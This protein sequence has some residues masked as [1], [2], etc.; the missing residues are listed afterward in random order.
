MTPAA[1]GQKTSTDQVTGRTMIQLRIIRMLQ[2]MTTWI[3]DLIQTMLLGSDMQ[4]W[5]KDHNGQTPDANTN[6]S[7]DAIYDAANDQGAL[8]QIQLLTQLHSKM[9]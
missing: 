2:R 6:Y 1:G 3:K 5:M 4:Q 8:V 9:D 7:Q